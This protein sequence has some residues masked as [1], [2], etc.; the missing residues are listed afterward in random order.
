MSVKG[1]KQMD[2]LQ[3]GP[4]NP[5]APCPFCSG[6]RARLYVQGRASSILQCIDC[7]G[8]YDPD[9]RGEIVPDA[10]AATDLVA[11]EY[12]RTYRDNVA[13]ERAIAEGLLKFLHS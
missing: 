4:R 5:S 8:L 6:Y 9:R 7:G 10:D 2:A 11:K 1:L 13:A 12:E 3:H